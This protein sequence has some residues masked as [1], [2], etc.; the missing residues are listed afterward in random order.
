MRGYILTYSR[1]EPYG[2]STGG[3]SSSESAVL[4]CGD[5]KGD[6]SALNKSNNTNIGA[7]T[8][9]VLQVYLPSGREVQVDVQ[10]SGY[11]NVQLT[12]PGSDDGDGR[13]I[14]GTLDSSSDDEYTLRN[15]TILK[16]ACNRSHS[17]TPDEF[18]ESWR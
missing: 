12:V 18:T 11:Q 8:V 13:G 17:C 2:F 5:L 7:S 6:T 15:R 3:T 9:S 14:C 16:N 1:L 10:R 4:H